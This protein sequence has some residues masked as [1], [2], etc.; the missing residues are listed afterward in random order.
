M[1][2]IYAISK[3]VCPNLPIERFATILIPD[4][5]ISY[6][7]STLNQTYI[8][9]YIYQLKELINGK[10]HSPLSIYITDDETYD[11]PAE[12]ITV[13]KDWAKYEG[14]YLEEEEKSIPLE[15]T[16]LLEYLQIMQKELNLGDRIVQDIRDTNWKK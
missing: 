11:A 10:R 3:H 13:D 14:Q 15:T 6:V 4:Q 9:Y 8:P 7:L 5:H 16:E 12:Y 1:K 2:Y